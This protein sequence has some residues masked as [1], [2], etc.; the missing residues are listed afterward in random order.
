M[1]GRVSLRRGRLGQ[2]ATRAKAMAQRE[3]LRVLARR[4]RET[5]LLAAV[6]GVLTG[7]AVALFDRAVIAGLYDR[8]V[9]LS[10]WVLAFMPLLG[11][12]LAAP[13]LRWLARRASPDTADAYLRSFHDARDPIR[14][15]QVPGKML[16]ALTT[17]GFGGA[18]GLEGPSL[19][20][21]ASI[22]T[23]LQQ[24]FRRLV[25][26]PDRRLLLVAGAA[27]GVSA[28]FKAPA[29]GAVFALE[30]PYHDDLA[31][32]M[33]LP[34]LVGSASSYLVYVAIS[35]TEPILPVHGNPAFSFAD[36][37]GAVILGILAGLGARAFA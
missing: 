25:G 35:G 33:L 16:A 31:R 28:I 9:E 18:M 23:F 13:S 3:E 1:V 17:L 10:P 5:I 21:G 30:V 7:L 6:T 36:L 11:L 26:S 19:Y 37:G 34:A 2:W 24:K 14:L 29:T 32:R 12:L 20:V 27:A 8:L 22:G 4:S 15:R